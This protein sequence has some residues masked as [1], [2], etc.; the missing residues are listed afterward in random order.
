MSDNVIP[1]ASGQREYQ[2]GYAA[3]L[4]ARRLLPADAGIAPAPAAAEAETVHGVPLDELSREERLKLEENPLDIWDKL[5]R[6]AAT[7]QPPE[8]G[9]VF[10][11]KFHGLFYVAPAQDSFMVRVRVPGNV[12]TA[13]QLRALARIARDWGNGGG[14][15]TTRGN[16][17]LREFAPRNI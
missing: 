14:D 8:G 2:D 11:F 12:I 17:Q 1:F 16:I 5:L 10:R 3:G 9:D 7:D 15:I 6:H 13:A 4:R